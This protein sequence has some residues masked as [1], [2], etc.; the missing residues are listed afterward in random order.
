MRRLHTRREWLLQSAAAASGAWLAGTSWLRAAA[1]PTSPVSVATC[2]TYDPAGLLAIMEKMFDRVGGLTRLVNGK[3]V[4]IKVNLTGAPESRVNGQP[5]E[6]THY[7][8]PHVIAATVH[9]MG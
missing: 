4:A 2:A 3:T 7:T 6:D 8:H 5:L 9:L 1:A